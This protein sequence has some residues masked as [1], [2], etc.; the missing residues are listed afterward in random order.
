MIQ[1]Q[2]DAG[3]QSGAARLPYLPGI[4]GLR[5][6]AVLAVVLYHA[7]IPLAGGFLGVEI[8]FVLSGYL[9]TALLYA[10][11]Q[12]N[13]T[14]SL[15]SFW[16]RRA[17]RL[18]PALGL[19]LIGTLVFVALVLP[20]ELLSHTRDTLA[21]LSYTMNWYLIG[22]EQPYFDPTLR[23]PLLQHLWSL[24]I[25]EQFYLIWPILFL[26]GMRLFG[27][28]GLLALTLMGASLSA[29]WMA[30][31][32]TPDM[33]PSRLY[34][35]T[36]TRATGLLL[37]AALGL[38]SQPQQ[39][40][41]K[42][43]YTSGSD[44]AGLLILAGLVA[45]LV[46]LTNETPA[47]YLGGFV[48][49]DLLTLFLIVCITAPE[50]RLLPALFGWQPLRYLGTRSY[51]I[52]LWH[53]PVIMVTRPFFD[54]PFDGVPLLVLRLSLVLILAEI[55]YRLVENPI[56]KHGLAVIRNLIRPPTPVVPAPPIT[57]DVSPV[58][59]GPT[60]QRRYLRRRRYHRLPY[61]PVRW[62]THY[63]SVVRRL[64]KAYKTRRALTP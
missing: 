54:V 26:V 30:V 49:V 50:G 40:Q 36:D 56:R 24:A 15:K 61:I 46:L 53:W 44:L 9:I 38:L 28:G 63:S 34:Y 51:S 31:H 12:A 13:G 39:L 6:L 33:D 5:A 23:P 60:Q 20:D 7:D 18:L 52:Y 47:L 1:L 62:P 59:V 43:R 57:I 48:A 27:R 45:L 2:P 35:G 37:G 55:S 41:A 21:T 58:P 8:F 17:R 25:E 16:L 22:T 3:G 14:I 10:E 11:W 19:L 29:V 4:D 32:Y 42:Q 64:P